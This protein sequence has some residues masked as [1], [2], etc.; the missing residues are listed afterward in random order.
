MYKVL[1]QQQLDASIHAFVTRKFNTA[2]KPQAH[3]HVAASAQ[4]TKD[5]SVKPA[6]DH[7]TEDYIWTG[8]SFAA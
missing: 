2:D 5:S 6:K 4:A 1:D 3:G 7:Q 8:N